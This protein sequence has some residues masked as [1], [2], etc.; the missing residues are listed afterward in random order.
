MKSTSL[1]LMYVAERVISI[2]YAHN[3]NKIVSFQFKKKKKKVN[4]ITFQIGLSLFF[5]YLFNYFISFIINRSSS[6]HFKIQQVLFI[7]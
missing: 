2:V 7:F 1:S 5:V 3:L 4:T 6:L